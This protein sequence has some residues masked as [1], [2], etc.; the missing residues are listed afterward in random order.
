[1]ATGGQGAGK[2]ELAG[3]QGVCGH[4][5]LEGP[6]LPLEGRASPQWECRWGM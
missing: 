6:G 5:S 3:V 4:A 2:V 1:M